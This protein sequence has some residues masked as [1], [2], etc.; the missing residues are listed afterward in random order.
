MRKIQDLDSETPLEGL[1][2]FYDEFLT[3]RLAELG[4]L[5]L[6]LKTGDFKAATALGHK[7]KGFSAPY[8][9]GQ[10]GLLAT[11]LEV[12]AKEGHS[13][14]CLALAKEIAEYLDS[15]KR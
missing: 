14:Q 8:G 7:W 9:F 4:E 2:G 6:A 11:E 12:A 5:N 10:L 1:E 15:K 13:E 3:S